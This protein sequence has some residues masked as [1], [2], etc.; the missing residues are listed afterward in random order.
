MSKARLKN[1]PECI[2]ADRAYFVVAG[3]PKQIY[4]WSREG[5]GISAGLARARVA[6]RFAF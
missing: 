6:D 3:E 1:W 5:V 4:R 2:G